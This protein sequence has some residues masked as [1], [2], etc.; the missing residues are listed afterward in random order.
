MPKKQIGRFIIEKRLTG[1]SYGSLWK[2][3]AEEDEIA[4]A[5]QVSRQVS[6]EMDRLRREVGALRRV[7]HPNVVRLLDI[8]KTSS[9][10]YLFMEHCEEGDL[11]GL[12]ARGGRMPENIARHALVQ[13]VAGLYALHSKNILHGDLR[14]RNILI[15]EGG[16]SKNPVLKLANLG[17]ESTVIPVPYAAPEVVYGNLG[18]MQA[19][20]WSVGVLFHEL[21]VGR[22]PFVGIYGEPFFVD[23]GL[24]RKP[25]LT[26]AMQ[27]QGEAGELIR[28]LLVRNPELRLS[29]KD[30]KQHPY[31]QESGTWSVAPR[32]TLAPGGLLADTWLSERCGSGAA[33]ALL[34]G[35]WHGSWRRQG[36]LSIAARSMLRGLGWCGATQRAP[37]AL[38]GG[39]GPAPA[40][41]RSGKGEGLLHRSA[42]CD[43]TLASFVMGELRSSHLFRI[44]TAR[45]FPRILYWR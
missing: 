7:E 28:R 25:D 14:P 31:L 43:R 39:S 6:T 22:P 5:R 35:G 9:S 42:L 26:N 1:G 20:L 24:A 44:H 37:V 33:L 27:V 18:D 11:S 21:L 10:I 8:K 23:F 29:S 2:A 36:L 13:V 30:L 16:S 40:A 15:S 4:T 19:D 45:M 3:R 38:A 17:S 41:E 12:L 34:A 32:G